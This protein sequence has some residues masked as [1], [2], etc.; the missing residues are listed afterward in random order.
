MSS[1]DEKNLAQVLEKIASMDEPERSLVQRV[2]EVIMAAAPTLKPRIWYGMP[3][4]AKSAS[5]PALVTLRNDERVN[6]ALTEKV[7]LRPAGGPDGS[8][9]PAAWYLESID[10]T[11][12][13]RIAEIVRAAM[14]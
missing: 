2:H 9:M 10:E 3:A 11:T 8:L 6:L 13:D 5:T 7:A 14:A 4:Y 1:K 12:E